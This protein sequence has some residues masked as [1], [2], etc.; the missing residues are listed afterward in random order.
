MTKMQP[1]PTCVRVLFLGLLSPWLA[2]TPSTKAA[3]IWDGPVITFSETT[4]NW[5]LPTNQDR[6]TANVWITRADSQGV[7]NAKTETNFTHDL[8]PADTAWADGNLTNYASLTYTNWE[9][10]A[11]IIHVGPPNTVG[12]DA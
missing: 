1:A 2:A 9:T 7:F 10:W 6:I 3:T 11:K 8:S 5:M 12:V 4:T